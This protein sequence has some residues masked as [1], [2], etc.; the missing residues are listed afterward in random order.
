[1]VRARAVISHRPGRDATPA[2]PG[3]GASGKGRSFGRILVAL[4]ALAFVVRV[5]YLLWEPAC[6]LAGDES[7]WVALGTQ[8]LGR[9][10]EGLNPLRV[11]LIFY[12]PLYPYFIA[13]LYRLL[14]SLDAVLCVQAAVGALLVPAVA[15]AGRTAFSSSVGLAAAAVV[16]VY[17]DFVW[18]SVRFWS[19]T[20]FIVT[21]WW[22]IERVLRADASRSRG[23]AALAGVVWGLST[24]TRE[25]SLYLAPFAALW[26]AR[27]LIAPPRKESR[28]ENRGGFLRAG[29]FLLALVL[30]LAPWTIRNAVVFHAFIPVSTMGASNL[31]Q[32]N[33]PLTHLEV[34]ETLGRITD[35]I[36]R[37]RYARKL[38]WQV[39]LERQPSW[40]FEKTAIQMPEFWKAGSEV[41]DHLV[42]RGSCGPLSSTTVKALE[43]VTVGP[44]LVLL[45]ISLVGLARWR[46]TSSGVLLLVLAG[47]YNLAHVA[48]YATT[49]FR[50]PILPVVFLFAALAVASP[51][52]TLAPL[53]GWRLALV[54]AL[55]LATLLVLWP[56]LDELLLWRSLLGL[57]P[58]A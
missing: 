28:A 52:D 10:H 41:L 33:V 54:I 57:P 34:H 14:G 12:P 25:L 55:V 27:G 11:H 1:M 43:V 46:V 29:V 53:R 7:S 35:P 31:W 20:L 32:G 8:E 9:P 3:D 51:R 26:L 15:R 22:G 39:I 42:G 40:I 49:R 45:G 48:A 23:P 19:E 30:T 4:T 16:A 58:P 17:P 56:G 38:A 5:A 50:L 36:E 44:Y 24:L 6:A 21:L 47:A 13:V 2:L 18:F 37:D